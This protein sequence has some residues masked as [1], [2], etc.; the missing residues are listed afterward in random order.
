MQV[1][2]HLG[3]HR[4]ATTSFQDYLRFNAAPLA[5]QGLV[6]W[7]PDRTRE[8]LFHGILP[9]PSVIGAAKGAKRA[10]GRLKMRLDEARQAGTQQLLISDENMM[11]SI[12]ENLRLADLYCGVGERLARFH[13][14]F[15]GNISVLAV[16]LRSLESY[17]TSA[18]TYAVARG[19]RVPVAGQ[20]DRLLHS[21]RSWRDVLTDIACSMPEVEIRV[22]PF[23][24]FGGRP[25]LQLE[26]LTGCKGPRENARMRHAASPRLEELRRT[27][28]T[29]AALALPQGEGRWRP[30]DEVQSAALRERYADDLMWLAAGADGLSQ[31][32]LMYDPDKQVAGQNLPQN[33]LT[34][35]RPHDEDR[36][37]AG[38][39]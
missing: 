23:E 30:L 4:C 18:L 28:P 37:L 3:A 39:G 10:R 26:L 8:G 25:E 32:R 2:V 34:R 7:G 14:A 27:M 20:L 5:E 31:I 16:N 1:I 22:L 24:T 38:S 6:A 9:N 11:G 29:S 36:R 13:E 19:H 35:G 33:D 17:W 21:T 15:D 12:R